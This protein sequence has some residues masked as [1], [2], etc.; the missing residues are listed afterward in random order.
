M[1]DFKICFLKEKHWESFYSL[2]REIILSDF[3]NYPKDFFKRKASEERILSRW[4][5]GKKIAVLILKDKVL[6]FIIFSPS[7]A[8]VSILDWI[9]VKKEFRGRGLGKKLLGFY[10]DWAKKSRIHKLRL[11]ASQKDNQKFYK[12]FGFKLEGV[13]KKDT[14]GLDYYILSKFV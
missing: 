2:F 14:Y 4:H 11:R 10:Q 7:I 6:G 5:K 9:G 3:Q 1:N 12:S 8:G 13:L